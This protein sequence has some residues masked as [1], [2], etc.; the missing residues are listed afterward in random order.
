M[1]DGLTEPKQF[2]MSYKATVSSFGKNSAVMA[3]SF[4]MAVRNVA[5]TWYSSLWPRTSTPWKEMKEIL[6]T[7]FQGF[8]TKP[9]TAQAL[10]QCTQGPDEYL[11]SF[12]RRFIHL[13]AQAPA[14][15]YDI[16]IEAMVK[17]LR[18][19]QQPNTSQGSL[20]ILL[21]SCCKKWMST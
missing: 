9:V 12:V 7:S 14:F 17:G 8:Q 3:K 10:F 19:G 21:R 11:Q 2:L 6:L 20:N 1:Y 15:Q 18:P 4:V 16:V 13:W 5:Q